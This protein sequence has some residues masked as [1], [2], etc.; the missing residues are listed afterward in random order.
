MATPN[1]RTL[2]MLMAAT[3]LAGCATAGSRDPQTAIARLEARRVRSPQATGAMR[4]LGIAYY[5]AQRYPEARAMLDTARRRDPRD[6]VSSLYAGLAAEAQQD[7]DGAKDA[8]AGYLSAG[9]TPKVREQIRQRLAFVTRQQLT[10]A[11]QAAL[12]A[13][14]QI[15]SAAGDPK[16]VAV[17]PFRFAGTDSSLLPLERGLADLLITDIARAPELTVVER[18]RM[19]ALVDEIALSQ[20]NRVDDAAAVRAGRMLRAG[21]VVQGGIT[22]TG[23]TALQLNA[24]VVDVG[25]AA[26]VGS[27]SG[28]DQLEQLF[29]LE[30][31]IALQVLQALGVT[32]TADQRAALD[33]RPTKSLTAFLAYSRGLVAEDRGDFSSALRSYQEAVRLDPGFL[34]AGVR[35]QSAGAAAAGAQVSASTVEQGLSGSGEGAVSSGAKQGTVIEGTTTLGGLNTTSNNLNP[36]NSAN[37]TASNQPSTGGGSGGLNGSTNSPPPQNPPPGPAPNPPPSQTGRVIITVP[38]P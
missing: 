8:Y 5:S 2:W 29:E 28:D 37:Q 18:D 4:A 34:R 32:L 9:R 3:A 33:Q 23:A 1:L 7:W 30:K 17:P 36:S 21:R 13:E 20:G 16:T 15:G 12:K 38:R 19:Q 14:A 35:Q 25:N 27:A 22:Q 11:A 6:G 26:A 24:A 31:R 10:S